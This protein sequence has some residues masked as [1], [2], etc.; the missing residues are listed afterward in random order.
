MCCLDTPET[1]KLHVFISCALPQPS[2]TAVF[3]LHMS[4][5][6]GSSKSQAST[7]GSRRFYQKDGGVMKS[8]GK[9]ML[10]AAILAGGLG[11]GA[12]TA[13]AAEVRVVIGGP[14]AYI[15]PCPGPGYVWLAGYYNDG[16]WVPGYWSY[17]GT[18]YVRDRGPVVVFDRDRDRRFYADRDDFRGRDRNDFRSKDRD[19]FR[20]GDRDNHRNADHNGHFRH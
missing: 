11:L 20:G 16:Y 6:A 19:D 10:G 12:T 2:S 8:F 13:Q 18:G 14:A 1:Q 3:V 7:A 17:S 4:G 9:F 5:A 15:P